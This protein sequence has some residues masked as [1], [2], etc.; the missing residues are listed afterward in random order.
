MTGV[1]IEFLDVGQGESIVVDFNES[2]FAVVDFGKQSAG[3]SVV[4]PAVMSR[5]AK[6]R[7][8]L[9]A[10]ITHFDDDH[11]GGLTSVLSV[12]QPKHIL[13]PSISVDIIEQWTRAIAQM[14]A[15]AS[16]AAV[17]AS[18]ID[19]IR[20]GVHAPLQL[21][22][23]GGCR[24]F[25]LSPDSHLEYELR[26]L[27]AASVAPQPSDLIRLRNRGSL[28]LYVDVAGQP[29]VLL[30]AEV[31]ADQYQWMWQVVTDRVANA[32][33]P[34]T[35]IKLSHH[36]SRHNN[37]DELFGLFASPDTLMVASA[38]GRYS[39][40]DVTVMDRVRKAG[41][42]PA[43]TN[44]G[45]GCGLLMKQAVMPQD[46]VA[47]RDSVTSQL[48]SA[49]SGNPKC[50][51]S[52]HVALS[53]SNPIATFSSQRANCPFGAPSGPMIRVRQ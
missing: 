14:E 8:F 19:I 27:L 26:D 46:L 38:G 1:D 45:A 4:V 51:G 28:V 11:A 53:A 16:M 10:A 2:W 50:H 25:A 52:I 41:A 33:R 13:L 23:M 32:Y 31:E 22:E 18:R 21:S 49:P 15:L 47:W 12:C 24:L 3:A 9:F 30:L 37:P 5:I 6:G 44:L 48:H 36:G 20:L 35:L 29:S 40:P 7:R 39:H 17:T 34:P 43:C 42:I